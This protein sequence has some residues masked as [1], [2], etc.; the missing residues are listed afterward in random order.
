MPLALTA[1]VD[2]RVADAAQSC[3]GCAAVWITSSSCFLCRSNTRPPS[4]ASRMSTVERAKFVI[5]IDQP[6][7]DVT[8]GAPRPKNARACRSPGRPRRSRLDEVA[9]TDSEPIRPPDPV[10]IATGIRVIN[11]G[12]EQGLALVG[13]PAHWNVSS[14][15]DRG[16]CWP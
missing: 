8:C 10:T 5:A 6:A 1:E 14:P 15:R 9:L 2:L 16:S 12:L 11:G 4:S 7:R 13:K 3:E